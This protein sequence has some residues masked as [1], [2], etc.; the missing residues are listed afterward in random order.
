M[1]LHVPL[2]G[3]LDLSQAGWQMMV[4]NSADGD[5]WLFCYWGI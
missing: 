2:G 5:D 3:T 4:A 1:K